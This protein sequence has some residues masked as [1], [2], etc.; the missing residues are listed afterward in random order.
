[1]TEDHGVHILR[2]LERMRRA[3]GM[4]RI[5]ALLAESGLRFEGQRVLGASEAVSAEE[6]RAYLDA[7]GRLFG[8]ST[9][10]FTRANFALAE[11]PCAQ[12]SAPGGAA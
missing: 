9:R 5:Q 2:H 10:A 1:M 6:C 8:E 12:E 4:E 11:C 7:V 3:Y